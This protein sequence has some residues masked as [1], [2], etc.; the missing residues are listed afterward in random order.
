MHRE[1]DFM[2]S[3]MLARHGIV[4]ALALAS[5]AFVALSG[6]AAAQQPT[7]SAVATA[8]ELLVAKG[9]TAMFEPLIPGM[10]E[11]TKN[12]FLPTN[13]GLFKDINEVAAKLQTEFAPRREEVIDQIAR[14][15]A[16]RFTEAEMREVIAFYRSPTGRKFVAQEPAVIDEGLKNAEEWARTMSEN[17]MNRFRAEMKKKG[18]DL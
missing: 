16:Q 8:K 17:V 13:P 7:P 9:A 18:H 5:L 6:P 1:E 3:T 11:N 2:I 4:T 15:Y 12:T 10:I 14:L